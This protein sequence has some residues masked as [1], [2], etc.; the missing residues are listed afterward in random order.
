MPLAKIVYIHDVP[1]NIDEE[2]LNLLKKTLM[3]SW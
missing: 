2:N 3:N 1:L